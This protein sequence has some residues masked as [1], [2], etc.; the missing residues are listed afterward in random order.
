ML[1]RG[2]NKEID[3]ED[4]H[5]NRTHLSS[6]GLKLFKKNR[7]EFYDRYVLNIGENLSNNALD[8]GQ[9]TH[10]LILEPEK[11]EEEFAFFEGATKRGKVWDAFKKENEGKIILGGTQTQLCNNMFN[12]FNEATIKKGDKTIYV[13]DLY[14]GGIPELTVATLLDGLPIKARYDYDR[15]KG[16]Y[17]GIQDIKTTREPMINVTLDKLQT[18]C[19]DFGYHISAAIYV[20]TWFEETGKLKDFYFTFLSKQDFGIKHVKASKEFLE[21]GRKEYKAIIK[22]LKE[23]MDSGVYFKEIDVEEIPAREA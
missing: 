21:D 5:A 7:K 2:I 13:K 9:Y 1:I 8:V 19:Y 16:E 17:A 11:V 22:E 6:S 10:T 12:A 18:I 14:K 15:E 20:D 4:Y 3:I 23:C